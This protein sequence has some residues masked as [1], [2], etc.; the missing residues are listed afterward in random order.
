MN[1]APVY[2]LPKI[3]LHRVFCSLLR[4]HGTQDWWPGDS[5]FEVMVGAILTQNTAWRNVERAI[6]NLKRQ[7]VLAPAAIVG[8]APSQLAKWLR[9]AG[10]F[11]VKTRRLQNF[12]AWYL[13]KGGFEQLAQWSTSELREGLLSVNGIGPETAD[14]I[15]LYAFER[16][17]FVIDS[18]TRR[19]FSRLGLI[20]GSEDY[21]AIRLAL[22]QALRGLPKNKAPDCAHDAIFFDRNR[23][24]TQVSLY[25]EY[26]ALIVLH[27]KDTCR[28]KPRCGNCC[29]LGDCPSAP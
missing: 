11:N 17:V 4:V 9:P 2:L 29:L 23:L 28:V 22:E 13:D 16:P 20:E 1:G 18:Y 26:H 8:S 3:V 10:Y 27:G 6:Y 21:E 19:L 24:S 25:Q 12:C 14:D 5:P 7:A 15:L